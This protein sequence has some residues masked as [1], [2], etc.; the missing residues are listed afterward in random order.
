M[1]RDNCIGK[2]RIL[3]VSHLYEHRKAFR[4]TAHTRGGFRDS[5]CADMEQRYDQKTK[6]F[7]RSFKVGLLVDCCVAL[8]GLAA[9]FSFATWANARAD[10]GVASGSDVEKS[11]SAE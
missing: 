5:I 1:G 3:S 4:T 7:T 10:Q 9:G 8:A 2:S 11:Q 6:S